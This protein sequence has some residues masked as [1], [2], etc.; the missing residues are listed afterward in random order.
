M[1]K[2]LIIWIVVGILILAGLAGFMWWSSTA[3]QYGNL[4]AFA[5][6]I[7]DKGAKFYG[8]FWCPHCQKQ[9]SLFGNAKKYLPYVECSTLDRTAQTPI[10]IEKGIVSY[11]TWV[12]P[13]MS[14]TT[15]EQE[16]TTLA[17]KTGCVLPQ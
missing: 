10:C 9:K 16:L 13:D 7:S 3:T 4:D 12:F 14:S 1:E 6:C 17:D 8:A 2:N 15:G 5:K 11:P